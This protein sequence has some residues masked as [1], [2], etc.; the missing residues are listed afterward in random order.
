M[1]V[2][3]YI[4]ICCFVSGVVVFVD[5]FFMEILNGVKVVYKRGSFVVWI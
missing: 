4:G 2:Y 3:V 1:D 5:G